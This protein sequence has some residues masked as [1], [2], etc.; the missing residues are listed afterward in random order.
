MPSLA[1]RA[2]ATKVVVHSVGPD[3]VGVLKEITMCIL[4]NGGSVVETRAVNLDGTFSVTSTVDL[5]DDSCNLA[6]S[7]QT[8]LPDFVTVVRPEFSAGAGS[9]FGRLDLTGARSA[10]VISQFTENIASRGMS[11]ATFRMAEGD[12]SY[13]AT[14]TLYS[15]TEVNTEWLENEFAEMSD[16]LDVHIKFEK[17]I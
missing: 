12:G 5:P 13:N 1:A 4:G 17:T 16:K 6:W 3:R 15:P 14:A 9:V 8:K 10:G 11:F 7:L 2:M